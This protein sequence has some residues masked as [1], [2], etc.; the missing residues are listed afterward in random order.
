[1][2]LKSKVHYSKHKYGSLLEINCI[3]DLHLQSSTFDLQLNDKRHS[4]LKILDPSIDQFIIGN[5]VGLKATLI[6]K[7]LLHS[8][9][10]I[11]YTINKDT[12]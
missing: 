9:I 12:K 8:C 7:V 1:M 4:K 11:D 2:I 6:R 10:L 5:L 3:T